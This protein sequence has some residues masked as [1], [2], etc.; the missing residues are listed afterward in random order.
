MEALEPLLMMI[1]EAVLAL[2][3]VGLAIVLLPVLTFGR[4][5]VDLRK[6]Q[7]GRAY[8]RLPSGK[9]LIDPELAAGV[10]ILSALG[11]VIAIHSSS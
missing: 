1:G 5:A 10:A 8:I 4:V 7:C 3:G 11:L 9:I 6:G 2:L